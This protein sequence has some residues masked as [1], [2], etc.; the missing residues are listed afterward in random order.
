MN[1]LTFLGLSSMV[2]VVWFTWR[3]AT[4]KDQ[5][6]EQTKRMSLIEAWSNVCIG[7]TINF[8]ANLWL[9]PLMTSGQLTHASNFWGGWVYTTISMLRQYTIR[10]FFN[11]H[12]RRFAA[13][14]ARRFAC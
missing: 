13:W 1:T 11:S 4:A 5:G 8:V 6:D 12:I 7:F 14:V 10:R 3:E 2:F 9:L